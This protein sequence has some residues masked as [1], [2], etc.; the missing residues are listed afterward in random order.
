[1]TGKIRGIICTRGGCKK[2]LDE[3]GIKKVYKTVAARAKENC[4]AQVAWPFSSRACVSL[5]AAQPLAQHLQ[6]QPPPQQQPPWPR[7]RLQK[8]L[9]EVHSIRGVCPAEGVDRDDEDPDTTVYWVDGVHVAG[10]QRREL[11]RWMT[12]TELHRALQRTSADEDVNAAVAALWSGPAPWPPHAAGGV[13]PR[14]DAAI[15]E[16]GVAAVAADATNAAAACASAAS[17]P[18][19]KANAASAENMLERMLRAVVLPLFE[20]RDERSVAT[21]CKATGLTFDELMRPLGRMDILSH[22]LDGTG[23]FFKC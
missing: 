1:M 2:W 22:K 16:A 23:C 9:H 21:V 6:P 12:E 18:D 5:V 4:I 3:A 13:V 17:A 19:A 8:V 15:G 11:S 14:S 7:Q 20:S 10:V